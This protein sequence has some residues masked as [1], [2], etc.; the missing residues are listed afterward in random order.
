M[1]LHPSHGITFYF[2]EYIDSWQSS[3]YGLSAELLWF[4][5][6]HH[7][8]KLLA[9]SIKVLRIT[10]HSQRY[11]LLGSIDPTK[12]K[13]PSLISSSPE[14]YSPNITSSYQNLKHLLQWLT[15]STLLPSIHPVQ[16][17]GIQLG[18]TAPFKQAWLQKIFPFFHMVQC[19]RGPLALPF[20]SHY[21]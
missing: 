4:T 2:I 13:L 21:S 3:H 7:H 18:L 19:I 16:H 5:P 11:P 9:C 10:I 6:G 17:L 12:Y 20:Y 15:I 14:S 8:W 1:N